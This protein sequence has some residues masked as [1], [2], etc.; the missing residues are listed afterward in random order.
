MSP[1]EL[2][3]LLNRLPSRVS[4]FPFLW[5]DKTPQA[6]A[7]LD[8]GRVCTYFD[9]LKMIEEAATA[10]K[11]WGVRPGD[12]VLLL[13]ENCVQAI[14]II[15]A[16]QEIDAWPVP[17]NANLT[18]A[19]IAQIEAHCKP[20]RVLYTSSFSA[21][22]EAHARSRGAES[23]DGGRLGT[24]H[25]G[26]LNRDCAPELVHS[27]PVL[28][29]AV[30]LYTTGTTGH[31][32]AVMLSHRNL[33]YN[34]VIGA[35]IR[36]ITSADRLYGS[37]SIAHV[38]G[39]ASMALMALYAGASAWLTQR[40]SPENLL[41][42]LERG[43]VTVLQA[44]PAMYARLLKHLKAAERGQIAHRLRYMQAGG[45][46]MDPDLKK[47][48]EALFGLPL[49]NS[50]GLTESS[51]TISITRIEAPRD[52]TSVGQAL[53]GV[54]IRLVD[55]GNKDVPS[56]QQGEMWARGPNIMLGYYKNPEETLKTVVS[57]GWLRTGDLAVQ[58]SDCSLRIVGRAKEIIIR[59]GFN[60]HPEEVEAALAAHPAV[61][62]VAVVGCPT[63]DG[64]EE[65][66]AFVE[67]MPG[68]AL[69][70]ALL[71]EFLID[72]L[73]GYKRPSRYVFLTALPGSPTGK[74]L[75]QK[76]KAMARESVKQAG[77][78]ATQ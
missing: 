6:P 30:L 46:P 5:A 62:R 33:Q 22:A 61:A 2:N 10:L 31:P 55:T 44:V 65:P 18:A 73:V 57:G 54:D 9:L 38:F 20:R 26:L 8:G 53:P 74:T 47:R 66:V 24:L 3:E 48:T 59:S 32:K 34:A 29:T 78:A 16:A 17:V 45:S 58:D 50:Y 25:I 63:E 4:R 27:D 51:P 56:G 1:Q 11:S 23:L 42:A 49:H 19:E 21:A 37:L 7:Y 52:D 39:L 41:E 76:L 69:D 67:P 15:L 28:Q 40:Y 12:R 64:D 36:Q 60:V 43:G 35:Q 77:S 72:K 71:K 75:R 68:S 14:A 13:N 70:E